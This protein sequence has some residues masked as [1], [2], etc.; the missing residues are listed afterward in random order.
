MHL[1][2]SQNKLSMFVMWWF[3]AVNLKNISIHLQFFL[4]RDL[5]VNHLLKPFSHMHCG[6]ELSTSIFHGSD[7]KQSVPSKLTKTKSMRCLIRCMWEHVTDQWITV[8]WL[9]VS[10]SLS[11]SRVPEVSVCC[12]KKNYDN[13]PDESPHFFSCAC[14]KTACKALKAGWCP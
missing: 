13:A 14:M 8:S 5:A 11:K 6:P 3:A 4:C 2:S 10:C 1:P 9:Y 7:N 12:M